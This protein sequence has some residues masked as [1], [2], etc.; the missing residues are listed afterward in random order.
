[1]RATGR[2]NTRLEVRG[3]RTEFAMQTLSGVVPGEFWPPL[4]GKSA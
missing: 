1:M 3:S 2:Q 4:E